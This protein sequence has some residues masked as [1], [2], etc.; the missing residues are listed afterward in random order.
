MT[1]EGLGFGLAFNLGST[2]LKNFWVVSD[3][4]AL[5]LRAPKFW[6]SLCTSFAID[7]APGF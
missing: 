5:E 3:L 2:A 4:S 6:V 7:F 1:F